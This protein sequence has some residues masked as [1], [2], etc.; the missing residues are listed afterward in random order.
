MLPHIKTI[1]N[2]GAQ[3]LCSSVRIDVCKRFEVDVWGGGGFCPIKHTAEL[4]CWI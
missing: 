3:F 4:K 2:A 1:A